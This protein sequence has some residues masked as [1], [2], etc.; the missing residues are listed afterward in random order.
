MSEQQVEACMIPFRR[1]SDQEGA[2]LGLSISHHLVSLMGGVIN[3]QSTMGE[4]TT[5]ELVLPSSRRGTGAEIQV[6]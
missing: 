6:S 2:G 4:G 3:V 5:V 1:F